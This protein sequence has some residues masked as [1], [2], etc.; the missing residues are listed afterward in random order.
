[1]PSV[2]LKNIEGKSINT[3]KLVD[4][5]HPLIISFFATWCKPC[6][7]ELSAISEQYEDWQEETGVRVIAVSTDAGAN[8]YKVKPLIKSKGWTYEVLLDS[9]GDFKRAMNVQPIPTVFVL[10]PKGKIVYRHTGYSLG[11]EEELIEKIRE[12]K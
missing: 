12:M 9:N 3:A 10:T 2:T 7:R 1:M 6:L 5:K 4:G 8:S 11:G